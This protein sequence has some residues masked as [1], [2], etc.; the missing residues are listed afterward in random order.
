[1]RRTHPDDEFVGLG[2]ADLPADPAAAYAF[3]R[4]EC[5]NMRKNFHSD[6]TGCTD[7]ASNHA[8]GKIDGICKDI[9]A[10]LRPMPGGGLKDT[11]LMAALLT[12]T[13]AMAFCA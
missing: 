4:R 1:M 9:E 12:V 2:A 11:S 3:A 7:A 6:K 5:I 10:R 8:F 13:V